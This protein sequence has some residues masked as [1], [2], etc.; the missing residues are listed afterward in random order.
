MQNLLLSTEHWLDYNVIDSLSIDKYI[1][2]FKINIEQNYHL[3]DPNLV[4]SKEELSKAG[5]F[6]KDQDKKRYIVSKYFLRILLSNFVKLKPSEISYHFIGNKKPAIDNLN[7]SVSHSGNY[8]IIGIN[9]KPIGV[10]IEYINIQFEID[11]IIQN[12]FS[13]NEKSFINNGSNRTLNFYTLWT[14]KEALLKATGEGLIDDLNQLE[15]LEK[16]ISRNQEKFEISSWITK[17]QYLISFATNKSD[18]KLLYLQF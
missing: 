7:F 3:I 5:R 9:T 11:D 14:R 16:T 2:L 6:L 8:L 12:S 17:E 13:E 1:Y 15:V 4:L 18:K 10:D